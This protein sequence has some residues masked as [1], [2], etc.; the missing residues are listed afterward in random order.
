[1]RQ[2]FKITTLFLILTVITLTF[3]NHLLNWQTAYL[4]IMGIALNYYDI[5]YQEYPLNIW[6]GMTGL[7]ILFQGVTIP[8]ILLILIGILAIIKPFGIGAGDFFYLASL[9]LHHSLEDI[10][11]VIQIA[12]LLGI[13]Y[14]L[15]KLNQKP[16]IAFIPFLLSAY[17]ILQFC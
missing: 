13:G 16:T 1:M 2:L 11:W 6:L 9:S 5:Q 10:L 7:L 15:L 12:S 14:Y 4:M 17:C 3:L 8:F